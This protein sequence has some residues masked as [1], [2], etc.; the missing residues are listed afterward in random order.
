MG[1]R[2][3]SPVSWCPPRV[4]VSPVLWTF[5]NQILLTFKARFPGDSQSLSQI[6]RGLGS[7]LWSLELLQQ[8][9]NFYGI[10]VLQFVY[11][12]LSS[13]IVGMM[14]TSSTRTYA[15]HH[16]YQDCCCQS[17]C[18]Q[19]KLV[20]YTF[21]GDPQTVKGPGA[22]KYPWHLICPQETFM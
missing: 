6:S 21:A 3:L 12:P 16:A 17:F 13:S 2:L 10:M 1:W 4:S 9:K 8:C 11:C 20:T 7:Q 15:T 22:H 5:C 18:P 19:S 14:V